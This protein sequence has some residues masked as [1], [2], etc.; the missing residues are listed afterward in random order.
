MTRKAAVL[1]D[2]RLLYTAMLDA[3][4]K[5]CEDNHKVIGQGGVV[6]DAPLKRYL[7]ASWSCTTHEF[8]EAPNPW[9][10]WRHFLS[11]DF[12]ALKTEKNYGQYGTSIP[13]KFISADGKELY[14]QS[15]IWDRSYAFALRKLFLEPYSPAPA[16]NDSS[17]AN[18][19]LAQRARAISKSTHYGL[20]CGRDCSDQMASGMSN[21]SEDDFDK[22]AKTADWWGYTWPRP[23][24]MNQIVY[25]TGDMTSAGGWYADPIRVQVRQHFQWIEVKG[26]TVTPAYPF[27]SKAGSHVAYTFMLPDGTWGDGVRI[28]GTPGGAS[29]FTSISQLAIYN[30][31]RW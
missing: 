30:K 17:D 28:I 27:S 31:N 25:T 10:P 4:K 1:T 12:G 6:Y 5:S 8:Y 15:N 13:S 22:E 7:F 11:I 3:G 24:H 18:L 23:Y 9:G 16:S 20:L 14:L 21:G 2:D 19:A 29:H 26:V